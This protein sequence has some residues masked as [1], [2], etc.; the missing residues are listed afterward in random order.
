MIDKKKG[1]EQRNNKVREE[2]EKARGE[3]AEVHVAGQKNAGKLMNKT[4]RPSEETSKDPKQRQRER[5][6]LCS[7]RASSSIYYTSVT[8]EEFQVNMSDRK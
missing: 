6:K 7:V 4:K 3:Q 8:A 1:Q 5:M 2:T